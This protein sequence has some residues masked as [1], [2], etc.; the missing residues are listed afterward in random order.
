MVCFRYMFRS[1]ASLIGAAPIVT[2]TTK[3]FVVP[4]VSILPRL[5]FLCFYYI[6]NY[7][8]ARGHLLRPFL[9]LSL[10]PPPPPTLLLLLLL[11]LL[12]PR[13]PRLPML[14]PVPAFALA[15]SPPCWFPVRETS[16]LLLL[17]RLVK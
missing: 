1:P 14:V 7:F 5:F 8:Q 13:P 11:P 10:P 9:L 12:P 17:F 15:A 3:V 2:I 6:T 4:S 16:C